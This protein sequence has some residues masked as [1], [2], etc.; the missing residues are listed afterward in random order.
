MQ[1]KSIGLT[2]KT[3]LG[4]GLS[5]APK[6]LW[7]RPIAGDESRQP[8]DFGRLFAP[9]GGR[10]ARPHGRMLAAPKAVSYTHLTLPTI[11]LV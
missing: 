1:R 9:S 11:L 7:L 8:F 4:L 6:G 3:V 10:R 2:V 5:I